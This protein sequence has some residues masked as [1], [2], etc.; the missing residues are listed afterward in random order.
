M[1][2]VK[3]INFEKANIQ[4][5]EKTNTNEFTCVQYSKLSKKKRNEH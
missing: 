2:K 3:K 5:D 1:V 4:L